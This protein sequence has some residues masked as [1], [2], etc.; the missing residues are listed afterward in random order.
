[1]N[2]QKLTYD[3]SPKSVVMPSQTVTGI[4]SPTTGVG[5]HNQTFAL[6]KSFNADM[7]HIGSPVS[8]IYDFQ[9]I[10]HSQ[11]SKIFDLQTCCYSTGDS[12]CIDNSRHVVDSIF[13]SKLP[14]Q[15][16]HSNHCYCSSERSMEVPS[17][18]VSERERILQLKRKLQ[19]D[20]GTFDRTQPL[21]PSPFEKYMDLSVIQN[22]PYW[23]E[24]PRPYRV[25]TNSS[26]AILS[27]KTRIRWTQDLH[28]RF[29]ECVNQLGGAEKATPKAILNLMDLEW[30][31]IFHVKSHL[32][33]YRI[34]KYMPEAIEGNAC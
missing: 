5:S 24:S 21:I 12:F 9:S 8:D 26:C 31:T 33:K 29:V 27:S 32:Q 15:S 16:N 6:A 10:N 18:N 14:L 2:T 23:I 30:L 20:V 13:H 22:L 1:M 28:D 4:Q 17:N 7:D 3:Y 19:G 34:A 25:S 11:S